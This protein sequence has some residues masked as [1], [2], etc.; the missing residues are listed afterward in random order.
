SIRVFHV[1]GVQTCALPILVQVAPQ[2]FA[3]PEGLR[4]ALDEGDVVDREAVFE[5]R[6]PIELLENGLGGEAGLD[7][8]DEPQAVLAIG[9][10]GEIGR[11]S[12]RDI[13]CVYGAAV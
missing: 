11:A 1:T 9:Q 13:V 8:D 3:Q 5:R 7:A 2:Q 6:E 4:T 10:V 12:C